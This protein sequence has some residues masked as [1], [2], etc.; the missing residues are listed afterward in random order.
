MISPFHSECSNNV[1]MYLEPFLNSYY[2]TYQHI[3]TLSS[4]PKGPLKNMVTC[5]RSPKL[6]E[7]QDGSEFATNN[8]YILLRYNKDDITN[9]S[10]KN[11]DIYMNNEDIPNVLSYLMENGYIVD[12]KITNMLYKSKIS[13]GGGGG[14]CSGERSSYGKKRIICFFS[15]KDNCFPLC[16]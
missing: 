13:I 5:I 10:G 2:K 14:G 6:S 11:L 4:I 16:G 15:Y 1:T 7:F 9:Y 3:I 12:T 8:L